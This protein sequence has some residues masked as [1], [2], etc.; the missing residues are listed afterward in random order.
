[1]KLLASKFNEKKFFLRSQLYA[2]AYS[3]AM[4]CPCSLFASVLDKTEILPWS[5][6]QLEQ[7][8][9]KIRGSVKILN[10]RK[11]MYL[12]T[13]IGSTWKVRCLNQSRSTVRILGRARREEWLSLAYKKVSVSTGPYC[14][15]FKLLSKCSWVLRL[16]SREVSEGDEKF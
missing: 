11:W 7:V 3:Y 16:T 2:W 15:V 4:L 8:Y 6:K 12:E 14:H 9:D 1:M 10:R 5:N 13:V